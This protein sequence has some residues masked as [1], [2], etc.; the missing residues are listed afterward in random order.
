MSAAWYQ[1]TEFH[2]NTFRCAPEDAEDAA[3]DKYRTPA[4]L[5]IDDQTSRRAL[6]FATSATEN[7]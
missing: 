6:I 7:G 5:E 4:A 2:E 3:A 1:R